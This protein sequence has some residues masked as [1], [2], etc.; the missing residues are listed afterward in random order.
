M[1]RGFQK[2]YF[3]NKIVDIWDSFIGD[4][5]NKQI[6]FGRKHAITLARLMVSN[7]HTKDDQRQIVFTLKRYEKALVHRFIIINNNVLVNCD[8]A[9]KNLLG[10]MICP[11]YNSFPRTCGRG[12]F[13][14]IRPWLVSEVSGWDSGLNGQGKP[15]SA[16]LKEFH[17]SQPKTCKINAG[18]GP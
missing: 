6:S 11:T 1:Q 8:I 5:R 4:F 13:S 7:W 14:S 9:L 16:L 10:S 17:F 12:T 3:E 2:E 18:Q 15:P